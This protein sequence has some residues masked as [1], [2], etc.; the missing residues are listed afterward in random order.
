[1][2]AAAIDAALIDA[3]RSVNSTTDVDIVCDLA[4]R[5]D[6]VRARTTHETTDDMLEAA[7]ARARTD[8]FGA[9]D[10]YA[11]IVGESAKVAPMRIDNITIRNAYIFRKTMAIA[12]IT[13]AADREKIL[14]IAGNVNA[15][16]DKIVRSFFVE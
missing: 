10:E 3:A 16:A 14:S 9:L 15:A 5:L 13:R 8:L 2:S 7:I 6:A 4:W 11:A 12:A 1:M